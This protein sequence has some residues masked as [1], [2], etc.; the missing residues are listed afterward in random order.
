MY[1]FNK[2]R[3]EY[4]KNKGFEASLCFNCGTC[5]AVCPL[6]TG[7][8]PRELFRRALLEENLEALAEIIYTCLLCGLCASQ[9]PQGVPIKKNLLILREELVSNV[10][11]LER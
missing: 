9:C 1:R 10:W 2:E 6:E 4:L 8:L 5:S 7:I 11:K 3:Y